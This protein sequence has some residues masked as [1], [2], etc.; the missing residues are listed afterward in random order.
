MDIFNVLVGAAIYLAGIATSAFSE[1]IHD[2]LY[3]PYH[4]WKDKKEIKKENVET[5]RSLI[6]DFCSSWELFKCRTIPHV[7]LEK[8][9]LNT[10]REIYSLISKNE[11]DFQK[12]ET[13]ASIKN[14]CK[15]FINLHPQNDDCSGWGRLAEN[16]I[17]ELY[18]EFKKYI[19]MLEKW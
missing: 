1:V 6:A 16:Q 11:R 9:L 4:Q 2:I 8:D 5:V 17:D 13:G 3:E 10:C 18:T 7:D 19:E 12:N 15:T 14:I